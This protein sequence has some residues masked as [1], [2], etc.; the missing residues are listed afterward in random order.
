M[1]YEQPICLK[2]KH[3]NL[4]KGNCAAFPDQIPDEIYLGDNNHSEPLPDQGNDIVF[5]PIDN[6]K[7]N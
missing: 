7:D 6:K 2:C 5:E 1:I 4:E 3:Y